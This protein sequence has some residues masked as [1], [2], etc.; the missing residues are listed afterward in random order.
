MFKF[1]KKIQVEINPISTES[2]SARFFLTKVKTKKNELANPKLV[3]SV[4][5]DSA[6]TNPFVLVQFSIL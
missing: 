2:K 6:V 4:K 3:F 5:V 1:I